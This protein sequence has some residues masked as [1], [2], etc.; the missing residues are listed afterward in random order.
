MK[1]ICLLFA[2]LCSQT[3]SQ[4]FVTMNGNEK[5]QRLSLHCVREFLML[6][7]VS[8]S[9][10]ALY[11]NVS[12]IL[13]ICDIILQKN[14]TTV[15]IWNHK[16]NTSASHK[17]PHLSSKFFVI[18]CWKYYLRHYLSVYLSSLDSLLTNLR[19][20]IKFFVIK[21]WK[22]YPWYLLSIYHHLI[23][24]LTNRLIIFINSL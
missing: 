20:I 19:I 17:S 13:M 2:D 8:A 23:C 18:K 7:Q 4:Y 14:F 21:C 3:Y 11:Y 16:G 22:S 1:S 15:V 24:H 6:H 12:E 5:S 10:Q 9:L